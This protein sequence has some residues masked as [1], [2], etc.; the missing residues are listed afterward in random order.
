VTYQRTVLYM[1]IYLFIF[2]M[3]FYRISVQLPE[4]REYALRGSACQVSL[5]I[6]FWFR[7]DRY[8]TFGAVFPYFEKAERKV[9]DPGSGA[10][11]IPGSGQIRDNFFIPDHGFR[12]PNP[13][14]VRDFGLKNV[15]FFVYWPHIFSP[16][17][18]LLSP[19]TIHSC[20]LHTAY[21]VLS[22]KQT[23]LYIKVYC[24]AILTRI[25]LK[26]CPFFYK[27]NLYRECLLAGKTESPLIPLDETLILAEIL[28]VSCIL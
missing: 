4:W 22:T 8:W 18:Y 17:R 16:H 6:F 7:L 3:I 19:N 10:F 15:K 23:F 12:I 24:T 20:C 26:P 28:Q 13:I 11:L 5:T 21:S 27:M 1:L 9:A 2:K 25:T 14:F